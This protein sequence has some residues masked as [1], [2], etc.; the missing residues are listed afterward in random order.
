MP[1]YLTKNPKTLN[2]DHSH[3]HQHWPL[4]LQ[5]P[6]PTAPEYRSDRDKAHC[7]RSAFCNRFV[8]NSLLAA[9]PFGRKHQ[10]FPVKP[11]LPLE[12]TNE[13]LD[14]LTKPKQTS[15]DHTSRSLQG[16]IPVSLDFGTSFAKIS[17]HRLV[18]F[19]CCFISRFLCFHNR[20]L[21]GT[22]A[23][24]GIRILEDSWKDYCIFQKISTNFIHITTVYCTLPQFASSLLNNLATWQHITYQLSKPKNIKIINESKDICLGQLKSEFEK[25]LQLTCPSPH[26]H[27]QAAA[28]FSSMGYTTSF[29]TTRIFPTHKNNTSLMRQFIYGQTTARQLQGRMKCMD[30]VTSNLDLYTYSNIRTPG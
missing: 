15:K 28:R 2:L 18:R 29:N 1:H 9:A 7:C 27:R 3:G 30:F 6:G 22:N 25:C 19:L 5:V 4:A 23:S 26:H 12:S 8:P 14:E 13:A 17:I 16:N 20:H 11:F 24:G 10:S 21:E